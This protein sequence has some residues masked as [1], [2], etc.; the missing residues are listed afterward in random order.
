MCKYGWNHTMIAKCPNCGPTLV[1]PV[2]VRLLAA[3]V[4][5]DA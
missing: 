1:V 5:H 4:L 2:N 3:L